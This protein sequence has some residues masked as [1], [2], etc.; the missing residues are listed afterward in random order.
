MSRRG[1]LGKGLGALIPT[2]APAEA[3]PVT[4][5]GV[6]AVARYKTGL[7]LSWT[8]ARGMD[9]Y[10]IQLA[11]NASFTRG[12]KR[13]VVNATRSR[14]SSAACPRSSRSSTCSPSG[15]SQRTSG[16][17]ASRVAGASSTPAR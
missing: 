14:P 15:R 11:T 16:S 6:K 5:S 4:P 1:G 12:V 8:W 17:G 3:A 13:V 9:K 2:A 10:D 7:R